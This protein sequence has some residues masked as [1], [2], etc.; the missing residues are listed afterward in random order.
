ME[1]V[2]VYVNK[3]DEEHAKIVDSYY[4]DYRQ[5]V[6]LKLDTNCI[7]DINRVR[8][9]VHFPYVVSYVL[10]DEGEYLAKLGPWGMRVVDPKTGN[11]L[12]YTCFL[13][14][15]WNGRRVTRAEE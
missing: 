1:W 14:K 9:N 7:E 5:T 6:F 11:R 15:E 12:A 10:D 3:I 2:T 13:P 4:S 8:K